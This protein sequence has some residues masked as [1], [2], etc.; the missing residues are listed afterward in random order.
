[1]EPLKCGWLYPALDA[2]FFILRKC[3]V[4]SE[5]WAAQKVSPP[6]VTDS[7]NTEAKQGW[8]ARS[9][10]FRVC[11]Y[12]PWTETGDR[13]SPARQVPVL[14]EHSDRLGIKRSLTTERLASPRR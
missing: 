6:A 1:V 11:T 12:K 4:N 5:W 8:K 9:Q 2:G 13:V 14:P 7:S 3:V 10:G